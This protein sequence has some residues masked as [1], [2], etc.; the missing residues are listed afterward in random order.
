MA[1]AGAEVD[2]RL[3]DDVCSQAGVT[4]L[5]FRALFA[6]DGDFLDAINDAL[7]DE[8]GSR[9]AAAVSAFRLGDSGGDA[10]AHA[11]VV[12]AEARPLTRGGMLFLAGR[13][14]RAL[15][16]ARGA[17]RIARAERLYAARLLSTFGELMTRLERVFTWPP[18]L[19]VRVIL[20]TYERSFEMWIAAGCDEEAFSASPYIRS[21]LP[22]LLEAMSAPLPSP[23]PTDV[24]G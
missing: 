21:T 20:E 17:E 15:R 4:P 14:L 18:L 8:C 10:L 7:V 5:M 13:R 2:A 16:D 3:I 24:L 9:L 12:L 22:R 1:S 11:A 23:R 19:A 6:S